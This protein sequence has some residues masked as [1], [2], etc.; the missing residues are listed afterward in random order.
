MQDNYENESVQDSE[1]ASYPEEVNNSLQNPTKDTSLE[2][3]AASEPSSEYE[4]ERADNENSDAEEKDYSRIA[5]AD[6]AEI[7][8]LFPE[9]SEL[10]D[11]RQLS[12]ASRFGEL[13]DAGL[14]VSEALAAT[15]MDRMV[16]SLA[17]RIA[18]PDGKSHLRSAVPLSS[19]TQKSRMS[20]EEL[21]SARELFGNLN[22]REL[23]RLYKR[24]TT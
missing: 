22:D 13:R 21:H 8:R 3:S 17:K 4:D 18:R 12:N 19:A 10:E 16:A 2:N 5:E 15:N 14:S 1:A 7:K 24:A 11:L 23:E 9:F 6:L 20:A